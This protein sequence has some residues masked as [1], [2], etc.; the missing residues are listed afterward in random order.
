[1]TE[2]A[3]QQAIL[4]ALG[5]RPDLRIWRVNAGGSPGLRGGW[6]KGAPPGHPDLTGILRG[7]R[8]F[9][10]EVKTEDGKQSEQQKRFEAMATGLDGLYA[11]VRSVEEAV[12]TVDSWLKE[13]VWR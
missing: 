9:G 12:A 6:V 10:I 2:Q 1:M 13:A 4:I 7:G 5:S 11:V 8:W 3:L